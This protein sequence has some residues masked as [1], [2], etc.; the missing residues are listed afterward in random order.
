MQHEAI[1]LIIE[2][3]RVA[4]VRVKTLNGE[5]EAR[6]DLTI[7][8]DGRHSMTH[9]RAGLGLQDFNAP[10]DVLWMRLRK[11]QTI[12]GNRLDFSVMA[13]CSSRW[14]AELIG[15]SD[16]LFQ[17]AGWMKSSNAA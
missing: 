13:N 8:A 17:K 4:G 10:I 3:E 1:D 9:G 2:N 16:S 14:I 7:S 6:G 11:A 5:C 12:P 15:R